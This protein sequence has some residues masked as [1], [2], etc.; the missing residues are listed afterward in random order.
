[1]K[2]SLAVS[3]IPKSRNPYANTILLDVYRWSDY[4][5]IKNVSVYVFNEFENLG[6]SIKELNKKFERNLRVV[7]LNLYHGYLTDPDLFI[8]Y[9]GNKNVYATRRYKHIHISY[10]PLMR[11]IDGL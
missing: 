1:M 4:P 9:A 3:D 6:Y 2:K 8:A 7:I 11:A 5:E 10:R